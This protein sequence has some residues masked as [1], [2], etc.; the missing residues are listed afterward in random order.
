MGLVIPGLCFTLL[1]CMALN[2]ILFGSLAKE[3]LLKKIKKGEK[4]WGL[5]L[6]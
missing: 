3:V 1:A 5:N 2:T 6:K 4:I